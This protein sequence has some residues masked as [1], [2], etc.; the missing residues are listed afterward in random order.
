MLRGLIHSDGCRCTNRVRRQVGGGWRM[1]EYPR[2]FFTNA[3]ADIRS[4]F[5]EACELTGVECRPNN[6]RNLSIARRHS[7]ALLDSFVE[8]K[9]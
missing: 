8:P 7:V 3:S 1:H 6:A 4:I 9:G 2:Y 5:V